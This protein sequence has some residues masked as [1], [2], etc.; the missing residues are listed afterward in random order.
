MAPQRPYSMGPLREIL[1]TQIS[2]YPVPGK[3]TLWK[4]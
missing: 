3:D 1:F 4:D 2:V